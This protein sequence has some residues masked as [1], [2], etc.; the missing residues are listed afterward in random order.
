MAAKEIKYPDSLKDLPLWRRRELEENI[1]WF[2]GFS[3]SK[4]L[5]YIDREWQET[6]DF[7]QRFG[8]T[9]P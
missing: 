9:K 1:L 7:I 6:Q 5:A 3:P 4:R 2:S 8:R